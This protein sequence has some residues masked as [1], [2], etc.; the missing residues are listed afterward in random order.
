[1]RKAFVVGILLCLVSL[2]C[3]FLCICSDWNDSLFLL[4]ALLISIAVNLWNVLH[5]W[6]KKSGEESGK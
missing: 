5:F 3:V 4:L 2:A 6:R 1:M